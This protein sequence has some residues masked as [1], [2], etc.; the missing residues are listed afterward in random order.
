MDKR[1]FKKN[2]EEL[3][4]YLQ[5]KRRGFSISPKK[6]KGSYKRQDFKKG[7]KYED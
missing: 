2:P 7:N 4:A 5:F 6:G 1:M 3:Q